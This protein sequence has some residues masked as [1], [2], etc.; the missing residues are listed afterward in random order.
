M[1][2]GDGAVGA[3]QPHF[4]MLRRVYVISMPPRNGRRAH[5]H[6]R[7][8]L[9]ELHNADECQWHEAAGSASPHFGNG[10]GDTWVAHSLTL[11]AVRLHTVCSSKSAQYV[12]RA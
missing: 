5:P 12:G 7:A 9:F 4:K 1:A 8:L 3:R 2:R 11:V 10:E 6:G